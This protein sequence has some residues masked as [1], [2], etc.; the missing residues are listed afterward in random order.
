[1]R[2]KLLAQIISDLCSDH[3]LSTENALNDLLG[4]L[5]I[6]LISGSGGY[7]DKSLNNEFDSSIKIGL[8]LSKILSNNHVR[9]YAGDGR[10]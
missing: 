4:Q 5:Y 9:K 8:L 6:S 7:W 3:V 2:C 1:M 10:Q